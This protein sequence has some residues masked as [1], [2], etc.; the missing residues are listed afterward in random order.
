[1]TFNE[2]S[3]VKIPALLHFIRLGY[4]YIPRK[5][6]G[7]RNKETNIFTDI[8]KESIKDINPGISSVQVDN[9][10][11]GLLLKLDYDD[12]GREFYNSLISRSGIKLFNFE[13]PEKTGSMLPQ[14]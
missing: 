8:F 6:H 7:K 12:L 9:L 11:D 1:M 4:T 14:S 2:D 5:E 13:E 10:L 3:R